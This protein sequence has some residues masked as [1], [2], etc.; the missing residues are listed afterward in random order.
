MLII[1]SKLGIVYGIQQF[2]DFYNIDPNEIL[3][4][5]NFKDSEEKCIYVDKICVNQR[6]FN[7][8]LELII[9]NDDYSEWIVKLREICYDLSLIEFDVDSNYTMNNL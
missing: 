7:I 5:I 6:F 4:Q 2:H 8:N 3:K 1:N 9:K